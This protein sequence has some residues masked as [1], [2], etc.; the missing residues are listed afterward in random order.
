MQ[1]HFEA[2][3]K[4]ARRRWVAGLL[5]AGLG[6]V[7]LAA[8]VV[9][10][11]AIACE[12]VLGVRLIMPASVGGAAACGAAAMAALW[13]I[14]R[15]T[16]AKVALL[17]DERAA[18]RERFSTT[19]AMVA[20]TDP[21]AAAAREECYAQA[22][23]IN[24]SPHFPIRPGRRWATA[25]GAW[26]VAA[27]VFFFMPMLDL[28]GA[29][30]EVDRL[31]KDREKA[32][33]AVADVKKA[34]AK[35]EAMIGPIK[36]AELAQELAALAELKP[37]AG[38]ADVRREAIRKLG[39]ISDKLQELGAGKDAESNK[40]VQAA[41]K[42]IKSPAGPAQNL[43]RLLS[44]GKFGD[45]ADALKELKNK[46][47]ASDVPQADKDALAKDLENL[48]KQIEALSNRQKDLADA[49]AA[50][51]ADPNLAK[52]P[53]DQLSK[54]LADAGLNDKTI[55]QL[56]NKLQ[57]SQKA[58]G[59]LSDLAKALGQCAAGM[60]GQDGQISPEAMA[61]LGD[62]L[63]QLEAMRQQMALTKAAIDELNA[64]MASL[65]QGLGGKGDPAQDGMLGVE[66]GGMGEFAEG[67]PSGQGAGTGGPGKGSGHRDTLEGEPTNL[68]GSRVNNQ[69]RAGPVIATWMSQEEQ[70]RGEAKRDF[71]ASLQAAKDRAAEAINDN[72]IPARYHGPVTQ[73]FETV[74]RPDEKP[75][76]K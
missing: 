67:N 41:M 38:S 13:L 37:D 31:A 61:A 32:A 7:L 12:R 63:S 1:S 47:A 39:E 9:A 40:M 50:A 45:A 33:A 29:K 28:L 30:A 56:M 69:N 5:L 76:K 59:A 27:A 55:Q 19:L 48:A 35:V 34:A 17:V 24:I 44:R 68:V 58:S 16:K 60:S 4:R 52:L 65:G 18:L 72:V 46:V 71:D 11:L 15:P 26:A 51:G 42:Q 73:Y 22:E 20:S 64:E 43:A 57:A 36:S 54:A 23:K 8:G 10:A 2:C 6:D 21:F 49:L 70:V 3:L 62:Q 66:P 74:G 75:E 53:S 14:R 25:A